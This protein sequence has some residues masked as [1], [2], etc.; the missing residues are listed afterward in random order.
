M[1]DYNITFIATLVPL[2]KNDYKIAYT[3]GHVKPLT[4]YATTKKEIQNYSWITN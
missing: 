2:S 4:C 3:K 1:F